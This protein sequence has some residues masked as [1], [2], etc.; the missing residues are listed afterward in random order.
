[1][2]LDGTS[3]VARQEVVLIARAIGND[4]RIAW[5]FTPR[6]TAAAW[7]LLL[8]QIP[9]PRFVVCDGQKGLLRA[10]KT[11][12]PATIVQRCLVHV[13]RQS[14]AWITQRPQTIAGQHLRPLVGALFD[15][16]T[17]RKKRK[18]L[19]RFRRWCRRWELF[20]NA[21]T[22]HPIDRRRWWYTHKKLRRVRT[23]IERSLPH[24]FTFVRHPA[25]PRTS[26]HVEGGINAGLHE[27]FHAHRGL[28]VGQKRILVAYFL[29]AKISKKTTRNVY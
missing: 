24:L 1:V 10:I 6:E 28:S 16:R 25:V 17:R 15:I 7:S 14:L 9:A 2:V 8:S 13:V 3:L 29:L 22:M 27:L 11:Y 12:W 20:L 5:S 26:N 4:G 18:W 21:R 19:R 23:L